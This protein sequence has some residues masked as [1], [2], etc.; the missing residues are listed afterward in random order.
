MEKILVN[1]KVPTV[2]ESYDLFVPVDVPIASLTEIIVHGVMDMCGGKY[3]RSG[4]EML[5]MTEPDVLFD[6][7]RMLMDYGVHSGDKLILL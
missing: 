2:S 1:V 5:M 7:H 4:K 6:P 3:S